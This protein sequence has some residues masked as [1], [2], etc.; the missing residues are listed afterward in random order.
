MSTPTRRGSERSGATSSNQ[1]KQ[2]SQKAAGQR[3]RRRGYERRPCVG[4][5]MRARPAVVRDVG[6]SPLGYGEVE[7]VGGDRGSTAGDGGGPGGGGGG[8]PARPGGQ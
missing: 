4:T 1:T 7:D 3:P 6:R 2:V 5:R 8:P